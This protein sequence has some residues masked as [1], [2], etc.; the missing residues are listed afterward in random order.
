MGTAKSLKGIRKTKSGGL[1]GVKAGLKKTSSSS[2]SREVKWAEDEE[3]VPL[4]LRDSFDTADHSIN[5]RLGES[6]GQKSFAAASVAVPRS[7]T[8][9]N[10]SFLP[11]NDQG[12][13]EARRRAAAGALVVTAA[14]VGAISDHSDYA[15]EY[16]VHSPSPGGNSLKVTV[17]L[18]HEQLKIFLDDQRSD[19]CDSLWLLVRARLKQ[20]FRNNL[21]VDDDLLPHLLDLAQAAEVTLVPSTT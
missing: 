18:S 4:S 16:T 14:M 20:A 11:R 19:D 15:I 1:K 21:D 8:V 2:L 13:A 3:P 7:E 10:I 12:A 5:R 9:R 6:E 17:A